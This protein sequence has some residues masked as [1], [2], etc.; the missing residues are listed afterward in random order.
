MKDYGRGVN[1][2]IQPSTTFR[3]D[4]P[5]NIT[6]EF[7]TGLHGPLYQRFGHPNYEDLC[8]RLSKMEAGEHA[9]LFASGIAATFALFFSQMSVGDHMVVSS[10]IYGG[11]RGQIAMLADKFKWKV[12]VVDITDHDA[13]RK[14][15]KKNTKIVFAEGL[16]NP[17]IIRS[18]VAALA[19]IC[20][21]RNR[22]ILLCIDNT[23]TPLVLQPLL[24]GADVVMHSLTKYVNGRSDAMGGALVGTKEFIDALTHPTLGEAPLIGA[25]LHPPVAQEMAERFYHIEYRVLEASKRASK[26]RALF[27]GV[28]LRV[29][30]HPGSSVLSVEFL[31][32]EYGVNFVNAIARR[33]VDDPLLGAQP[34]GVSA[35]SLG[36]AHTY[37]WC[38]TR[39]RVEN[40]MKK[41]PLL[42][43][44]PVPYGFVR[45]AVG[46][47][48]D[49]TTQ[50]AQF[51]EVLNELGYPN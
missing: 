6:D 32:E 41:W 34:L 12:S 36:S 10:R 3:Q 47:S 9:C 50:F 24:L 16:S 49:F 15:C 27:H 8:V 21:S 1:T 4:D 28:G 2:P 13:V 11:T 31:T 23:F 25:V 44:S 14:A 7:T 18:D 46:Y 19:K 37:L 5:R 22:E 40:K 29:H 51:K 30:H 43:F 26:L 35:V 38:T 48:G 45:V 20:H 17:E 42:P 33:E 39:A